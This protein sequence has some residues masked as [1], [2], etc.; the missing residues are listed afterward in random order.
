MKNH[1][2]WENDSNQ[3]SVDKYDICYEIITIGTYVNM[4]SC[5]LNYW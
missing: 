1:C 2:T 3:S 4:Y 5:T